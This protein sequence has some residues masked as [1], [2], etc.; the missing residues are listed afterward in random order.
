MIVQQL[1]APITGYNKLISRIKRAWLAQFNSW[2]PSQ[3][4]AQIRGLAESGGFLEIE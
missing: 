4:R 2:N 1:Y 3:R